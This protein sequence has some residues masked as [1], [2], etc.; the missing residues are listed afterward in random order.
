[1]EEVPQGMVARFQ[2]A[3]RIEMPRQK[4]KT[5]IS[6]LNEVEKGFAAEKAQ[7]EAKRCMACGC[8]ASH[9]C[10]LRSYAH[11][12]DAD[13]TRFEGQSR[14][15]LLDESHPDLL[16]AAHK[17]IQCRTCIRITEE[18]LGESAMEIV[19]RGF[20]A[21]LRPINDKLDLV[22]T[23]GLIRL[24]RHCPVGALTFK[25]A[26]VATLNPVFN[27]PGSE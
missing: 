8:R 26:S 17:C 21:R 3:P 12:F 5:R 6:N 15:Y 20:T 14:E 19:G 10:K 22:D 7:E 13:P 16:Y 2:K 4:S 25:D 1:M 11:L 23:D 27:R 9:D 18:E 24:V